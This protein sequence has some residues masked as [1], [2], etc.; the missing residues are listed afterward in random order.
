METFGIL[1]PSEIRERCKKDIWN[2]GE[3]Q[4]QEKV[5]T[6]GIL[7]PSGIRGRWEKDTGN[8]E[9]L[10]D[11]E[12]DP[13]NPGAASGQQ[14][15][16]NPSHRCTPAFTI[17]FSP[18][19]TPISPSDIPTRNWRRRFPQTPSR[20]MFVCLWRKQGRGDFCNFGENKGTNQAAP[21]PYQR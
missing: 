3:L 21:G 13:W 7:K 12:K 14:D 4:G 16:R 19:I 17:P 5:E 10:W 2:S 18:T 8:L 20:E 1:E 9:E 15:T 6:P 11:Q